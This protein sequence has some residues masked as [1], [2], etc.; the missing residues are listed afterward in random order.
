M[1]FIRFFFLIEVFWFLV[2]GAEC[3]PTLD[4]SPSVLCALLGIWSSF[5][6]SAILKL[7]YLYAHIV[8]VVCVLC[9]MDGEYNF[10]EFVILM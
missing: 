9:R 8:G 1:S 3:S 5:D 2:L 6:F 7:S 10:I 4:F